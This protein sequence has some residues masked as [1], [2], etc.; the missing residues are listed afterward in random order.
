MMLIADVAAPKMRPHR[1][2]GPGFFVRPASKIWKEFDRG[3]VVVR[4]RADAE[5]LSLVLTRSLFKSL[6]C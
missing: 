3:D 5:F 1:F 4:R 2:S 6:A